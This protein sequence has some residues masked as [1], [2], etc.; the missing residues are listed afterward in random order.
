[1]CPSSFILKFTSPE[2]L[3]CCVILH[4]MTSRLIVL[5][6][7]FPCHLPPPCHTQPC[8]GWMSCWPIPNSK[9]HFLAS[10]VPSYHLVSHYPPIISSTHFH[11]SST[12]QQF[13]TLLISFLPPKYVT[14]SDYQSCF[15]YWDGVKNE[16]QLTHTAWLYLLLPTIQQGPVLCYWV[17]QL[18]LH[19][20]MVMEIHGD[21]NKPSHRGAYSK[22]SISM[23]V[24]TTAVPIIALCVLV[25]YSH[26]VLVYMSDYGTAAIC[27]GLCGLIDMH[28]TRR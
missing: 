24:V 28:W 15:S 4:R 7:P 22:Y 18:I 8:H 17:S 12:T 21:D 14:T 16:S 1:M 23:C 13:K 9:H 3:H 25:P 6:L 2:K 26:S 27:H 11:L 5:I 20:K 10:H 19:N